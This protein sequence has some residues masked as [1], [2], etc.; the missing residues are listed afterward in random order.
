MSFREELSKQYEALG[1]SE[2]VIRLGEEAEKKMLRP[3]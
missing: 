1:I 3:V 2:R